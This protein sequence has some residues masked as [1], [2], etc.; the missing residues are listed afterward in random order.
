MLILN[1]ETFHIIELLCTGDS[2]NIALARSICKS[3]RWDIQ[4]L[5]K[6]Y[7]YNEVEIFRPNDFQQSSLRGDFS[8]IP[9][10]PERARSIY[11][12]NLKLENLQTLQANPNISHFYA[13]DCPQLKSLSGLE[14]LSGLQSLVCANCSSLSSLA[15]VENLLQLEVLDCRE[16]TAL[17]SLKELK[18]LTNLKHL[19]CNNCENLQSLEGIENAHKLKNINCSFC[20]NL[21]N[22]DAVENL[23]NLLYL[24]TSYSDL[25]TAAHI[26]AFKLKFPNCYVY[27]K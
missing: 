3:Q 14:K 9:L 19:Q 11:C 15:G 22:L 7:H 24:E 17:L 8:R 20:T 21:K 2:Q 10:Y 27:I 12:K 25:I 4:Q 26:E 1:S 18:H 23:P 6:A 5:I 16:C 13:I